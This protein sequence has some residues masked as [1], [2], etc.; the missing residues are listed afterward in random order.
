MA[1]IV[2]LICCMYDQSLFRPNDRKYRSAIAPLVQSFEKK[3]TL[4]CQPLPKNHYLQG[5]KFSSI[6]HQKNSVNGRVQAD[7]AIHLVFKAML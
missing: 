6:G 5:K 1:F 3:I 4:C 7:N 2:K